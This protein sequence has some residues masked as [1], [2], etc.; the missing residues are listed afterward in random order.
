[1]KG[2]YRIVFGIN[3]ISCIHCTYRYLTALGNFDSEA[4]ALECAERLHNS[5]SRQCR[6]D[7]RLMV[8]ISHLR[9][10]I[11]PAQTNGFAA[12]ERADEK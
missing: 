6:K 12:G 3:H 2:K 8:E 7:R 1:M 10:E 5:G 9:Y 4:E 11:N